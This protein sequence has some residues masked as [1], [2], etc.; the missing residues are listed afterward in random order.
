MATS[1]I[2]RDSGNPPDAQSNPAT[3]KIEFE[4]IVNDLIDGKK[5]AK[6]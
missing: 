4:E 2:W 6:G 5:D 1:Y 3:D